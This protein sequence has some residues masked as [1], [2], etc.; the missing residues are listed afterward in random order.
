MDIDKLEA[1][2]ELDALVAEIM[3][4]KPLQ[5]KTY[6]QLE[7]EDAGN[8]T[9]WEIFSPGGWW[10]I[11]IDWCEVEK[12]E[13]QNKVPDWIPAKEP[14]TDIAA[15]WEVVEE[16]RNKAEYMNLEYYSGKYCFAIHYT[17]HSDDRHQGI[18]ETAPLAICKAALK[19]VM[20]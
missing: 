10:K 17:P 16:L 13:E 7:Q 20:E 3:E 8:Y 5:T 4:P 18:A 9:C 14:S 12:N 15:A 6:R 2:K 19:A 1:G 11:G